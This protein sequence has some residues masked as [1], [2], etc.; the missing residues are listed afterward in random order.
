MLVNKKLVPQIWSS[1]ERSVSGLLYL[2]WCP[3]IHLEKPLLVGLKPLSSDEAMHFLF[4]KA[5]LLSSLHSIDGRKVFKAW[6]SEKRLADVYDSLLKELKYRL[7]VETSPNVRYEDVVND[8]V[9]RD[10]IFKSQKKGIL[11]IT[12]RFHIRLRAVCRSDTLAKICLETYVT[13]ENEEIILERKS[14]RES[15]DFSS[16]ALILLPMADDDR[17]MII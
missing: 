1:H 6:I 7:E 4:G 17:L 3:E 8:H 14:I 12:M 2:V 16:R 11:P 10:L 9:K 13:K 5:L 15:S